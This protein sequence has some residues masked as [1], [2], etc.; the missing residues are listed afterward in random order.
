MKSYVTLMDC[1]IKFQQMTSYLKI[2]VIE[3]ENFVQNPKSIF[4]SF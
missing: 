1:K 3:N 4:F 2:F